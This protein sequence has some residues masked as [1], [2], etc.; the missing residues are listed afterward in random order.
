[1]FLLVCENS[2]HV[3]S[4]VNIRT[5]TAG[6]VYLESFQA[7]WF[8]M[9]PLSFTEHWVCAGNVQVEGNNVPYEYVA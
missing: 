8:H 2:W 5:E 1:M 9:E 7:S 6:T 4:G 3:W